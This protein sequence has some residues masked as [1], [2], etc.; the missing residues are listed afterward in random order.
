MKNDVDDSR[1][2]LSGC[3]GKLVLQGPYCQMSDR[4]EPLMVRH[5][6]KEG[7]SP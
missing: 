2:F 3:D 4:E 6:Y 1:S 7:R 5:L